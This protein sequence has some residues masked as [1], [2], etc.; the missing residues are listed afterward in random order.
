MKKIQRI[1]H[2]MKRGQAWGI[3]LTIA[4]IIFSLGIIIFYIYIINS[5]SETTETFESLSYDGN[6]IAESIL[7]EGSPVNW[8]S[9]DVESIGLLSEGKINETKLENFYNLSV[10]NYEI[11][12]SLFNIRYDYYFFLNE[13]MII[14]GDEIDGIGEPEAS[15]EGAD[16]D[17]LI[18]ISRVGVYKNKLTNIYIYVWN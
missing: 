14:S 3:D 9:E 12:K 4:F 15:R 10:N 7:S 2:G 16:S 11:T 17:N 5:G 8:S 6:L 1:K 18:K 13:T